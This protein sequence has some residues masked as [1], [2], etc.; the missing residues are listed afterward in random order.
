MLAR[1]PLATAATALTAALV[2]LS[3]LSGCASANS[4]AGLVTGRTT[5][6][7]ATRVAVIGDSIESG[8]GL[9]PEE[10]WPALVAADRGWRLDNLSVPGAGFVAQGSNG[11]DFSAQVDTAIASDAELVLIGA[12]DNDL[13]TDV[14]EVA[15]AMEKQV[16]RLHSSL[17][18]A[19]I[20]GFNALSGEAGDD[21]LAPFDDALQKAVEG[22]G[23]TWLD[24]GQP[25]RDGAGLVQDDGEHPTLPEQQAIA[26]VV[27][28]RLGA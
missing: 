12:S 13:G 3:A 5:T 17:P 23:G 6:A 15:A 4:G 10:A 27:E 21:E 28:T 9:E 7:S 20:V 8:L 26:A 25:Y 22:V 24:L 19:H 18:D 1:R 16:A 2:A 11:A 14:S